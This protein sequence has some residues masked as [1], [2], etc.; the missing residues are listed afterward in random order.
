MKIAIYD[1]WLS[2][3]GGGEKVATVMAE[4][5]SKHGHE[6]HLISGFE[7]DKSELEEKMA[8]DLSKVRVVAWYERS[9]EK[10]LPKTS[11]YDLFINVSFLDHLP[12]GAKKSIYY[13][14][15]PTPL[16]TTLLGF[17]KYEA[18]LPLLRKYLIIPEIESGLRP[19]EDVY[20]RGG[21]WL[22]KEN[23]IIFSNTPKKFNLTVRILVEE[24]SLGAL[25]D[26]GFDS[27]NSRVLETD[28]FIDHTFNILVY[29]LKIE[30]KDRNPVLKIR[31]HGDVR[32][33]AFGLVSLTVLNF[34]FVLWNLIKRFLP[35][36]EMALY[37]SMS[38]K[39]AEGLDT[40]DLFLA[41]SE[42][43]RNWTKKYLVKDSEILNPPVDVQ[44]FKPGRKKNIIL[45]VGRFFIGGHSKRQDVLL[46]AFK[47]MIDQKMID[48]SWELHFAGGVA[49]GK[50]NTDYLN[51]IREESKGY[52]VHFHLFASFGELK[53]LYAKAKIYWHAT[54]FGEDEKRDPVKFEHFGI[55]VV[56]AMAAGCLPVVFNGGGLPET[57]GRDKELLWRS[58]SELARI[59]KNLIEDD[60]KRLKLVRQLIQEAKKY[61]RKNF[62]DKLLNF[63][64]RLAK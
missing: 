35:R 10:L 9:Y 64:F 25:R 34:R 56:E 7:V 5:L 13:V 38:Y 28:R 60:G 22:E 29:K 53:A 33:N 59:T 17:I 4:I 42:F 55:T 58:E 40:Y 36:Y 52:P 2:A 48:N 31:V 14:H 63:V 32:T 45:N 51:K 26:I 11:E 44:L 57:V 27:P 6:V 15:F 21:R 46:N 41:N 23:T 12:S 1:K 39:V 24:L 19:I 54:G 20:T 49:S 43:T 47:R 62:S 3:L 18:I 30:T 8:V 61:S 37:G 50:D 16:K